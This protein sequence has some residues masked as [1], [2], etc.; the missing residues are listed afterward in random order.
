MEVVALQGVLDRHRQVVTFERLWADVHGH[1]SR[2]ELVLPVLG[3]AARAL[4]HPFE[5]A[6]P[7][8]DLVHERQ[9]VGGL[10]QTA[11]RVHPPDQ[12]LDAVDRARAQV[13]A[14]LVVEDELVG[15]DRLLHLLLHR[16]PG[17]HAGVHV[18]VEE[19]ETAAAGLLGPS[20]GIGRALDHDRGRP[21]PVGGA[22]AVAV[23]WVQVDTDAGGQLD[24]H[25]LVEERFLDGGEHLPERRQDGV[26]V[27][28]VGEEQGE[29]VA[30]PAGQGVGPSQGALEPAA[31]LEHEPVAAAPAERLVD[32]AEVVQVEYRQRHV[33]AVAA[34]EQLRLVNAVLQ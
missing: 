21:R 15:G 13:D 12:R 9:E 11:F 31:Q 32:E 27:R 26:A 10:E 2:R 22:A 3:L 6:L 4:E 5:E 29:A 28:Q 16:R 19:A 8:L 33:L 14:R 23:R 20:Q 34:S 30:A 7:Q 1:A 25:A 17:A 18:V 24:A